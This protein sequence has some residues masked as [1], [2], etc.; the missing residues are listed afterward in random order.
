MLESTI[1][2]LQTA[3]VFIAGLA[4]RALK[5]LMPRA[6]IHRKICRP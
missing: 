3:L 2:L 5:S 1:A 4:I 6:C